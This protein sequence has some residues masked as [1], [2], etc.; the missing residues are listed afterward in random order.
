M[1]APGNIFFFWLGVLTKKRGGSLLLPCR[2]LQGWCS[3]AH[4]QKQT[5]NKETHKQ[6]K[7]ENRG[8]ARAS[9]T[10]APRGLFPWCTASGKT[11]CVS[12]Q[13]TQLMILQPTWP[14]CTW[15]TV[16][17]GQTFSCLFHTFRQGWQMAPLF[18]NTRHVKKN[19]LKKIL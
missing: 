3:S 14:A 6:N 15:S 7:T 8:D 5:T 11:W 4:T 12:G 17:Q 10:P 9:S 18:S 2:V 19:T 16:T 1:Q 13:L